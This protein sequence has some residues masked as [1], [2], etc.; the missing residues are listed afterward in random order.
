MLRILFVIPYV[1]VEQQVELA[2]REIE[3]LKEEK[4]SYEIRQAEISG[5]VEVEEGAADIVIVR[6]FAAERIRTSIPKIELLVSPFDMM[7][8]VRECVKLYHARKIAFVGTSSMIYGADSLDEL[9]DD[10]QVSTFCVRSSDELENAIDM[11]QADGVEAVI[12]GRTLGFVAGQRNVPYILLRSGKE[13]IY[14]AVEEAVT[15][16]KISRREKEKRE[17]L[18]AIMDYS[19]EG[20]ISTDLDGVILSANRYA[21]EHLGRETG[22]GS[23]DTAFP[24]IGRRLDQFLPDLSLK[25]RN[26]DVLSK[27]ITVGKSR[28]MVNCVRLAG[29]FG[30][31]GEAT[32]GFIVTFRDIEKI[33]E[34]EG[35]IRKQLHSKG[36][37]AKYQFDNIIGSSVVMK[38][39]IRI[40]EKY[41]RSESNVF[42]H[43]ETGTGKEL[44]AQSIHNA[45]SRRNNPFVAV[46]CAALPEALL[47]SELFG[48]VEGAFTGAVKG[49][50]AGLFE[51]AHNGTLFLDEI[52]EMAPNLQ[53]RLLRVIQE[54]EIM[55]LGGNQV[56]P[57]DVRIIAASN[58]D[59]QAAV[60]D[61]LF[62]QDLL[63][64]IDVLRL[65][66]P[67]LRKRGRDILE[68]MEYYIRYEQNRTYCTLK[69]LDEEAKALMLSC[70]W[71]G[72]VR[73]LR[74][75]CERLCVLCEHPVAEAEDIAL[76]GGVQM[77]QGLSGTGR[78]GD[79]AG[80]T[81]Y[82]KKNKDVEEAERIRQVLK[83]HGGSKK[84]T[85]AALN[86][87][88]STL[89]R[90]IKKYGL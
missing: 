41:A 61:G 73:E 80:G 22:T 15:A 19:F 55:R 10:V 53:V 83:E 68:L 24:M 43:G 2:F 58:R 67:P 56:I 37:F 42:I 25:D 6:G 23:R 77:K 74:N 35:R 86:I 72:N 75:F 90:K 13:S 64:R 78:D 50:R 5:E 27:L 88:T 69:D 85:A 84:D 57:V 62:R 1:E 17:Y 7:R 28:Y 11:L 40:A 16:T 12:G 89:W 36:L 4:I 49:G 18:Q 44:F 32:N 81:A 66:L 9:M 82:R 51:L 65:E 31:G 52:G 20:I 21:C 45:S 14:Q 8:A 34:D 87:D 59:M 71:R 38:K 46:N 3:T 79:L 39:T 70:P 48:Y 54:K 63:Y 60:R 76:A 33:Q 26:S 30:V 47:E 29:K